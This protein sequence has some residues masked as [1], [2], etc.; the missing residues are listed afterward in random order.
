MLCCENV[1][2]T[3]MRGISGRVESCPLLFL[4]GKAGGGFFV[5]EAKKGGRRAKKRGGKRKKGERG[6][7][8]DEFF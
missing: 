6:K 2:L 5:K 4:Y 7:K 1:P 3:D 8:W